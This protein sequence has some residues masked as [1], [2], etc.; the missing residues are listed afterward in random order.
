[1]KGICQLAL[2]CL[3][4]LLLLPA[5]ASAADVT[6]GDLTLISSKRATR[7]HYDFTYKVGVTNAGSA[8]ANVTATVTSTASTTTI[9]DGDLSFSDLDT[10]GSAT[11]SDTFTLRQDRRVP[12]DLS[13]LQF[14]FSYDQAGDDTA[15]TLQFEAPTNGAVVDTTLPT[16]TISFSDEGSGLDLSSYRTFVNGVDVTAS[17]TITESGATY[18]PASPLPSGDNEAVARIADNAGN[19]TAVAIRFTISVFRAIAD[20]APTVGEAPLTVRF[21]TRAEFTGGSIEEYRWDFDNDGNFDTFDTVARDYSFTYDQPGTVEAVLQVRNNLGQS[22]SDTCAITVAGNAPVAL[23]DANPSNGPVPLSVEFTGT[24]IK[25]NGKIILHEWDLDGDGVFELAID[26]FGSAVPKPSAIRF[27]L[28][29]ATCGSLSTLEFYLNG[30]LIG[31]ANGT[32]GC[33][34]NS[35]E[36]AFTFSGEEVLSHWNDAGGNVLR[37]TAGSDVAVGYIEA[38]LITV[39]GSSSTCI[40]DGVGNQCATRDLC[41]GFQWGGDFSAS[42]DPS[43]DTT[44]STA[45]WTYS[46]VGT[47][48]AV[49]RVTDNEGMTDTASVTTTTVRVGGPG[50]P[51]VTAEATPV[52]GDAPLT[53]TFGGS[54]TDDGAIALWEWDFDGDGA[55]DSSSADSPAATFTY[56]EAGVFT[57]ALRATDQSGLSSIDTVDIQVGLIADLTVPNDSVDPTVSETASIRT[58][59]SGTVPIR[60]VIKDEGG[61]VVRVLADEVRTAGSYDDAWDGKNDTGQILP[62]G[63]YYAILEYEFA[64]EVRSID[65]TNTTGGDRYNP[66]R[67]SLPRTFRPFEDDLLTINFTVPETSGASEVQAFIGLFNTDTRFITLVDRV[68]FGTGA[69]TIHWD[70][71]DP[72]GNFAVPPPGDTFLF[73]I[74]GFTLPDNAIYLS[75][76]P[77]L[78]NVT[79]DPNFFDPSTPDFLSPSSPVTTVNFDLDKQAD[80]ELTVTNLKTGRVLRRIRELSVPAGVGRMV[81]WDGHAE[82][83]VFADSGDYRLSI[84]AVDSS[85]SASL[86]RYALVRVFY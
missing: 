46:E 5:T 66:A 85:G 47:V 27:L 42:T 84:R 23:A 18:T 28:N 68:P 58:T 54:A 17:T 14:D 69:H 51:V 15:P 49:F 24:G 2:F 83:G 86:T 21:R 26:E 79:V 67:N 32:T 9:I 29:H 50:T 44:V 62:E 38:E 82:D 63:T 19:T 7:T 34:C 13:V 31:S 52:D 35:E 65:L 73:G 75:R 1:M 55:F 60:L 8:I 33:I 40:Y 41:N 53:V 22:A 70:G 43:V 45:S 37:V 74:W 10:G 39:G 30:Q 16:F 77:V 64:G 78:S 11:S 61:A 3:C 20:C 81:E 72:D 56:T 80:V 12:F 6:V 71:L 36:P 48:N 4:S 76:A 57:A 59:L 25:S